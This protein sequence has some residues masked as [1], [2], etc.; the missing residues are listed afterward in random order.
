MGA[1]VGG[2]FFSDAGAT[3]IYTLSLRDA[4]PIGV[5]GGDIYVSAVPECEGVRS[6]NTSRCNG[7]QTRELRNRFVRRR[8][9]HGQ[10]RELRGILSVGKAAA[11]TAQ[12]HAQQHLPDQFHTNGLTYHFI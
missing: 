11:G 5:C 1:G 7:R 12:S 2:L 9:E 8:G 6:G 3:E 10:S 4:L